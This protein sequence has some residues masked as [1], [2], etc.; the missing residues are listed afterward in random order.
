MKKSP[1]DLWIEDLDE[2][3]AEL[4]VRWLPYK[5]SFIYLYICLFIHLLIA[6]PVMAKLR[7]LCFGKQNTYF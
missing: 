5:Y 1:E 6:L 3:L 4:D 2:F 7:K